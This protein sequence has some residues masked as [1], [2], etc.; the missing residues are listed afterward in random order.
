MCPLHFIDSLERMRTHQTIIAYGLY[1]YFSSRRYIYLHPRIICK[2]NACFHLEMSLR[3]RYN[4]TD[5]FVVAEW[6][7]KEIFVDEVFVEGRWSKLLVMARLWWTKYTCFCLLFHLSKERTI[8]L[9]YQF[10]R[11]IRTRFENKRVFLLTVLTD[12]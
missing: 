9:C 10:F 5:R 8:F 12:M 7:I 3:I 2:E 6:R 11:Q 1:L 4:K